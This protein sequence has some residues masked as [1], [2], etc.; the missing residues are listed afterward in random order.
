MASPYTVVGVLPGNSEFDRRSAD[1][2]VPLAFPPNAARDYHYLSAVARLKR[3]V[4]FEQAQ[5][6]M[7]AIAEGI[8]TRYPDIKKGWGAT[9][10]R[11]V[12]RVVGPQLRLSLRVLMSAVVAVLLIGCANLAN[13]LMARATL[14]SREIALRLALGARR[15]RLVRM[16]L[17][18]SLLLSALGGVLGIALRLRP[19]P[20]DSEP[21]AAVLLPGGSEHRD[22]RPGAGVSRGRDAADEHGV[23]TDARAACVAARRRRG[24]EGRRTVELGGT[25][26]RLRASRLRRRAGGGGVHPARRRRPAD[27]QLPARHGRRHRLRH[28]RHRRRVPAAADGARA[29]AARADAVR[30][31][32]PRRG[33]RG[34]GR[35]G[36]GGG[37]R[38]S[39]CAAGATACRS[40]CRRSRTRSSGRD[41]RSSR[42][43][44]SARSACG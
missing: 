13:L 31:A 41:S 18:E 32:G 34:A 10:D 15:G 24:A 9:V 35:A 40:A 20:L 5:A 25:P 42:P 21:A 17:T 1:L 36:D 43:A 30:P 23:R 2:W 11:Y 14:R 22:G 12:D 28:R 8:A 3:G 27:S 29:R 26:R 39:R 44:T 33:A 38:P 19:A 37:H 7:S 6:E 4:S 16:L